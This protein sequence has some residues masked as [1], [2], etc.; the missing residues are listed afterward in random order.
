MTTAFLLF[1]FKIEGK[2]FEHNIYLKVHLFLYYYESVNK[3]A[4]Y[5]MGEKVKTRKVV[6]IM[7]H[8]NF[9]VSHFKKNFTGI[10]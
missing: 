4:S 5:Y 6:E 1:K 9:K 8:D 3:L 7:D 10:R 2:T